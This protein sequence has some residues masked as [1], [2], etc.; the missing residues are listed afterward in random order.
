[1]RSISILLVLLA[2]SLLATG[3]KHYLYTDGALSLAY[4]DPGFSATYNYNP[5]KHLSIGLGAQG[6]VYHVAIT[7]PRQ[8]TPAVFADFRFHVRPKK[9]SQYFFLLDLGMNFYKHKDDSTYSGYHAYSVPKDNG[10]YLGLGTGYFLRLTHRGWGAYTSVKLIN[11]FYKRADY[12]I[13]THEQRSP[14]LGEGTIVL[15]LGFRF[16]DDNKDYKI[17]ADKP[18]P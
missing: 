12:N 2:N 10:V 13:M 3:Q 7:N 15:S 1:M 8:F 17:R 14:T 18:L 9:I 16:G 6:Y 11:N 4:F 5:V